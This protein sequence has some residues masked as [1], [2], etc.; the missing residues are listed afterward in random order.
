RASALS[1]VI[2]LYGAS[3][4]AANAASTAPNDMVSFH[5]STRHDGQCI[6]RYSFRVELRLNLCLQLVARC[7]SRI[8][9]GGGPAGRGSPQRCACQSTMVVSCGGATRAR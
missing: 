5:V 4:R 7:S 6:T 1:P 8:T 9:C 3:H 2:V